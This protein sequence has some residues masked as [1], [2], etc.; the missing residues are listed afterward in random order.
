MSNQTE[1][2][3]AETLPSRPAASL[4]RFQAVRLQRDGRQ[5]PQKFSWGWGCALFFILPLLFIVA[6]LFAPMRNTILILGVDG[7]LGRAEL[8]RTDTIILAA[9][10]P[11]MPEVSMLTIPRDLWVAQPD[12]SE[13]RINTAFFFAEA[14]NPGSGARATAQVV[15]QNFG[16]P[17]DYTVVLCMDGVVGIVDAL[18]G[19]EVSLDTPQAGYPAGAHRLSG[20]QALAFARNRSDGDDFGRMAQGQILLRGLMRELLRPSAWANLPTLIGAV[21]EAAEMDIP[22]WQWPRLGLAFLRAGSTGMESRAI[23]REMV[24]PFT[25]SGGAQ[26]LR[27]NWEAIKPVLEELFR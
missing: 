3:L 10:Y 13:N 12:G 23:D 11:L 19:I 8:G 14:E 18:G 2:R 7:G 27:P 4:G 20:E 9:V 22:A 1:N 25:T 26:V 16:V 15:Y 17:V 5:L 24:T 21:R 6:Y